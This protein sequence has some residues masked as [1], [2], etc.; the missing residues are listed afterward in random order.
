MAKTNTAARLASRTSGRRLRPSRITGAVIGPTLGWARSWR[1]VREC[2]GCSSLSRGDDLDRRPDPG[3]LGLS[4]ALGTHLSLVL[5][6]VM[7]TAPS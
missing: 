4:Q 2:P 7:I 1:P 3:Q 5:V 6:L